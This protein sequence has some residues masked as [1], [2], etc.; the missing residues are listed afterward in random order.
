MRNWP[1]DHPKARLMASKQAAILEAA[2][3]AF[4]F[5]GYDGVS[6][7]TIAD[8]AGVSLMTLYRHAQGKDNLF[9]A[10]VAAVCHPADPVEQARIE[11]SLLKPLG[12]ILE[13]VAVMFQERITNP[14]TTS[15]FR[16][17]MVE[18]GR[19][20]HL[21]QMAFEGLIGAHQDTLDAFLADRAE[22]ASLEV[23]R[24]R[25]LVL[26]FLD[27]LVGLDS[28]RVLLGLSGISET[29]RLQRARSATA[30]LLL[31]LDQQARA[32]RD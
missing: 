14:T 7:E 19:H 2:R 32:R 10:V 23:E 25:E 31:E 27:R 9:A 15:L 6:M 24:R 5:H 21:A 20:P 8:L 26:A 11:E 1:A 18:T 29:E 30:E 13:F 28:Y 3:D 22:T 12:E 4:L 17:V 16:V